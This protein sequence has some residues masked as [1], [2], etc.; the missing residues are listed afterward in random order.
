MDPTTYVWSDCGNHRIAPYYARVMW[1]PWD[2]SKVKEC[3]NNPYAENDVVSIIQM[4]VI[5]VSPAEF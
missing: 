1:R 2:M 5:L 3:S 4:F